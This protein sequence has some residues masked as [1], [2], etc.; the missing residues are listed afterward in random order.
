MIE[1]QR[2]V[3]ARRWTLAILILAA[4]CGSREEETSTMHSDEEVAP[5]AKDAAAASS[6]SE[7]GVDGGNDAGAVPLPDP[8]AV[9][10]QQVAQSS[11]G[12]PTP[13][14]GPG[15]ILVAEGT[16]HPFCID[17]TEVTQQQY[18]S[19]LDDPGPG[20]VTPGGGST[21]LTGCSKVRAEV[22][23]PATAGYEDCP[24]FSPFD[25]VTRAYYP[26]V[27]VDW[28]DAELFCLA[29]GKTL[30]GAEQ[31]AL[32]ALAPTPV[33]PVYDGGL[34]AEPEPQ[35][36]GSWEDAC[37]GTEDTAF[38]YGASFSEE[39][40]H[41]DEVHPITTNNCEGPNSGLY[42]LVGNV[43]E[44]TGECDD[45]GCLVRGG[46]S[47]LVGEGGEEQALSCG[48][49]ESHPR[50]VRRMFTGFRCCALPG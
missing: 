50:K 1:V 48:A 40:C 34:D 43:S 4:A 28:C 2:T 46:S 14:H 9:A 35:I 22:P 45:D 6:A 17:K 21:Q 16:K 42:D 8:K 32:G 29:D 47:N 39:Q 44:W 13:K 24:S 38:P 33:L 11:G 27:C 25:P 37:R 20:L 30:C 36:V 5:R 31:L 7:A 49:S 3:R 41:G 18:G 26:V 15:M 12:C 19:Y 23:G 10:L